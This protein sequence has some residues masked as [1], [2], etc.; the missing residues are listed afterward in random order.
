[1]YKVLFT[2]SIYCQFSMEVI[3]STAFGHQVD[4]LGG[5]ATDDEL[6]KATKVMLNNLNDSGISA[7]TSAIAIMCMYYCWF[8]VVYHFCNCSSYSEVHYSSTCCF[9]WFSPFVLYQT[10]TSCCEPYKIV[11]TSS[12]PDACY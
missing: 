8:T 10:S 5:N 6:Y 11:G 12:S 3:L 1:M 9:V 4:I 2:C 7:F